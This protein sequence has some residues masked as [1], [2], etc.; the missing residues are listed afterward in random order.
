MKPS[1]A[2]NKNKFKF[3]E[4]ASPGKGHSFETRSCKSSGVAFRSG[5]ILHQFLGGGSV[6]FCFCLVE[7]SVSFYF[8]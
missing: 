8:Q 6:S 5:D 3:L 4:S 1:L 7:M 2:V